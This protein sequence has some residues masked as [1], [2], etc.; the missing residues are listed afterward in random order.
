MGDANPEA[1]A[2]FPPW[3]KRGIAFSGRQGE[4]AGL[5]S[6]CNLNTVCAEAKC[7]NRGECFS[8]GSAAFLILGSICTRDCAFCGVE[9][10]QPSWADAGEGERLAEAAGRMGLKHVVVTSVTRDDLPDGGAFA[11]AD[12]VRRLRDKISGVTVEVLIPDFQGSADALMT[13]LNSGPDVLNH[14]VET[15]P[16]LYPSIRPQ[17][18]YKRSLELIRRAADDGRSAIKSG[19]MVGLGETVD[20]VTDLMYDLRASGCTVITIGQY[21]RPSRRQT[22]VKQFI[23]PEQF[24]EY[25]KIA[26]EMG[27]EQAFCGPYVRS[28]YRAGATC[29]S[30]RRQPPPLP[31]GA[32]RGG[33][34]SP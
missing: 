22:P 25:E 19:I 16:R 26:L 27:F 4:V 5:I 13:V 17:A 30:S 2:R 31:I 7:P 12:V 3:L 11:F 14:N 6:S 1:A 15:V 34:P 18:I 23:T 9:S 20:E 21:L 8:K 24:S 29:L 33:A 32:L 10:G 28:S